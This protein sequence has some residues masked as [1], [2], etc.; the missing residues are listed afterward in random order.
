M[1]D[2]TVFSI[3]FE[4]T[5]LIPY[6]PDFR[7]T[8]LAVAYND[9]SSDPIQTKFFTD[10]TDIENALQWLADSQSKCIVYNLGFDELVTRCV[11]PNIK[12][13]WISDVMR[14]SQLRGLPENDNSKD[15]ATGYSLK[16]TTKRFLPAMAD[17]EQEAYAWIRENLCVTR[18]KEGAHLSKLPYDILKKYNE[19]DVIATLQLFWYFNEFF[20][21]EGYDWTVD[22]E[23]YKTLAD[24]VIEAEI[25]GIEVDRKA[26]SLYRDEIVDEVEKIDEAFVRKMGENI[27]QVREKLKAKEQ[28]K[29]KKKIITELPEFNI[30]SKKHLEMLFVDEL[31][32]PFTLTTPSGR[33]SFK[34]SHMSQWGLG[35]KILD[36]RGK[37]LITKSHVEGLIK[38]SESDN[39]FHPKL[40]IVGTKTGRT[41][42]A[43]TKK[44]YGVSVNIQALSRQDK[45]SISTLRADPGYVLIESDGCRIEPTVIAAITGDT[46]YRLINYDLVGKKPYL[47][48]DLLLCDDMYLALGTIAPITQKIMKD[49]INS[50]GDFSKFQDAW[51]TLDK[52]SFIEPVKKYRKMLKIAALALGYGC[53]SKKLHKIFTEGGFQVTLRQCEEL[54][55]AFW[56]LFKGVRAF[57]AKITKVYERQG[58]I[59]NPL[60]YRIVTEKHKSYNAL[61]QSS[62][63]GLISLYIG[64]LND[65]GLH[66]KPVTLIHDAIVFQIKENDVG[67]IKDVI[68]Q[69]TD[70]VN[71]EIQ[72]DVKIGFGCGIGKDMYTCK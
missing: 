65:S 7:I 22:W 45:P 31:G 24:F 59:Y 56:V 32:L 63:N 48:G 67:I 54:F 52:D 71:N 19:N 39:R 51:I 34:S 12:I 50:Y 25:R 21:S 30:T 28:A 40:R 27:Q 13:N 49:W 8:S 15:R 43:S 4:T 18:G 35:G 9:S 58:Y 55:D 62:V 20:S 53:Q 69:A 14:L 3:D 6:A 29:Y 38:V 1:N 47:N 70:K 37:R 66:F 41:S 61:I 42:S 46:N 5:S 36:K 44:S 57:N 17:Y 26:L 68:K 10:L 64:F 60:G 2:N 72:W 33:P 11:F 23:L 16:A